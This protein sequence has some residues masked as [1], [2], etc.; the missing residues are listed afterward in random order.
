MVES[1]KNIRVAVL[2]YH[3]NSKLLYPSE[4]IEKYR[5][6]IQDQTFQEF[7]IFELNYNGDNE[8]IFEHSY[9]ESYS[10]PT[11]VHGLN[12]LLDKCFSSGYD[13]VANTNIDDWASQIWLETM[14]S[15]INKGYDLVSSNFC[16]VK[17]DKIIK[18]HRFH[19]LD[20]LSELQNGHNPVCHPAVCYTK[21]FWD[22]N[23]YVPEEQ[24]YE[25]F[26]LWKRALKSGSKFFINEENLLFHRIHNNAVCQ[27]NNR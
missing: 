1:L 26:E 5:E 11:F 10:Y 4:W 9:F 25:D 24:P 14:I 23:R 12:Y 27:S 17:D 13:I 6:S 7:Q 19:K 21:S 16:L 22:N 18:Y 2:C 20:I 15:D 8:R 3:K